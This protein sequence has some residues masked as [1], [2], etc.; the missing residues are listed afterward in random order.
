M[1]DKRKHEEGSVLGIVMVYFVVFSLTGLIFISLSDQA[2]L[3]NVDAIHDYKNHW[4]VES[5]INEALWRMNNGPATLA[6]FQDGMLNSTYNETTMIL[7]V[8]TDRWDRPFEVSLEI[9]L[10]HIFNNTF[11]TSTPIDTSDPAIT[12]LSDDVNIQVADSLPT[13]DTAYYWQNAVSIYPDGASFSDTMTPG[14]H[15]IQS[16]ETVLGNN[17]YLVGTLFVLGKLKVVGNNVFLKAGQDSSGAYLPA[18]IVADSVTTTTITNITIEGAIISYGS[19]D[20]NK[21][22]L[23]GPFIGSELNATTAVIFDDQGSDQ[24]YTYYPGF[25]EQDSSLTAKIIQKGSWR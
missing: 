9:E 25:G 12:I 17:T 22:T 13:L 16:G 15:Y 11:Y 19:F 8:S 14:I 23:T 5:A 18:L 3:Q 6:T 21:G 7:T 20:I 24:Y 1:P 2:H 10:D 4:A